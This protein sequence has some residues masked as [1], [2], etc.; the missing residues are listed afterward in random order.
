[1]YRIRWNSSDGESGYLRS[2]EAKSDAIEYA[3]EYAASVAGRGGESRV[4]ESPGGTIFFATKPDG[5]MERVT[6][7][8]ADD[9]EIPYRAPNDSMLET[10]DI[11]GVS[12]ELDRNDAGQFYARKP[13]SNAWIDLETTDRDFAI[14]QLE[15]LYA[16]HS[17]QSGAETGTLPEGNPADSIG[18]AAEQLEQATATLAEV[19]VN[20]GEPETAEDSV[21][22]VLNSLADWAEEVET[23]AEHV[24]EEAAEIAENAAERGDMDTAAAASEAASMA[25]EAAA[26]AHAAKAEADRAPETLHPYFRSL[27]RKKSA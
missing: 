10:V 11:H 25:E 5:Y 19:A 7:Y 22:R 21:M 13:G 16:L 4:V 18:E 1:M 3:R 20:S 17:F 2:F 14:K 26:E 12:I 27:R 8:D 24:A 6:V 9:Y 23:E 15:E